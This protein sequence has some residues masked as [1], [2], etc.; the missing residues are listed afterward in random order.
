MT[1]SHRGT[2]PDMPRLPPG[3]LREPQQ[4][5]LLHELDLSIAALRGEHGETDTAV[6]LTSCYHNL[7]RMWATV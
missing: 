1:L 3:V 5:E 7:M 6:R 4:R 2:Q